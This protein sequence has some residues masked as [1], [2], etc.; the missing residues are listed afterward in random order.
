LCSSQLGM[1]TVASTLVLLGEVS[2]Y[3]K[4]LCKYKLG[5]KVGRSILKDKLAT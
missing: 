5:I 3:L 4:E 1:S 2:G